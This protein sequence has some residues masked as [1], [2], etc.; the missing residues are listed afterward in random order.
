MLFFSSL[1]QSAL[2]QINRQKP[3][4]LLAFN[5][6]AFHPIY[7]TTFLLNFF[8][9]IIIE[10]R[11]FDSVARF[12]LNNSAL[13]HHTGIVRFWTCDSVVRD[14]TLRWA[15]H[16]TWPWGMPVP[17]QCPSCHCIQAWDQRGKEGSSELGRNVVMRCS[18][19]GTQGWCHECL[20]FNKPVHPFKRSKSPKGFG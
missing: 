5:A 13:A 16:C 15:H 6:A 8:Q 3:V 10:D 14:Y 19:Q 9:H 20:T 4:N 11:T 12:L 17:Y 18:Y 1:F 2:T 7:A